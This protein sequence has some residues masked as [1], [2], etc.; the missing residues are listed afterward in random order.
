MVTD[1]WKLF[2]AESSEA[3]FTALFEAHRDLVYTICLRILG[4]PEDAAD[5]FQGAWLRLLAAQREAKGVLLPTSA[6]ETL[7]RYAVLEADRLRKQRSRRHQREAI[8]EEL[9]EFPA[10]GP[11]SR[12]NAAS[13][14]LRTRLEAIIESLP[15]DQRLPI[16]LHYFHGMT[17]RTI[18]A[19][20]ELPL[21]T[22]ATR[23][24]D[25]RRKLEPICRQAGLGDVE[26]VLA[27]VA[28]GALLIPAPGTLQA[29]SVLT[30][31]GA[32]GASAAT[33]L[34]T[35]EAG[36]LVV[37]M[38]KIIAVF[39]AAVIVPLV[40]AVALLGKSESQP[41]IVASVT[42]PLA[43]PAK[44]VVSPS[45]QPEASPTPL[46]PPTESSTPV[47][48]KQT[49]VPTPRV[50]LKGT[51][52]S[53]VTGEPL[54]N[55]PMRITSL[56]YTLEGA[57]AVEHDFVTT[58]TTTVSGTFEI[59]APHHDLLGVWAE[60]PEH[61]WGY[62]LIVDAQ[63][64]RTAE[65]PPAE[66]V[67]TVDFA[68]DA[69]QILSVQTVDAAGDPLPSTRIVYVHP[70]AITSEPG[71][72]G[73]I[74]TATTDDRGL[75]TIDGL[76]MVDAT[77]CATR[78][79]YMPVIAKL[80]AGQ[81]AI[82]LALSNGGASFSG[83]VLDTDDH[84]IA[85]AR[86]RMLGR[87]SAMMTFMPYPVAW[88]GED[89][90]FVIENLLESDYKIIADAAGFAPLIPNVGS[91]ESPVHLGA[92]SN[93]E[94]YIIKL[95]PAGES[96]VHGQVTD[97][98][99]G[100]PMEGVSVRLDRT[101]S[102]L[103]GATRP[104]EA[105]TLSDGT[106][107]IAVSKGIGRGGESL[108]FEKDGFEVSSRQTLS[109]PETGG[110]VL[111]VTML[112]R[113]MISGVIQD[114]DGLPVAD[115]KLDVRSI[116]RTE[117][118]AILAQDSRAPRTN[119]D[120]HFSFRVLPNT[121]TVFIVRKDDRILG[122]SAPI[123]VDEKSPAPIV[124]RLP[125]PGT[126]EV[127]VV[128]TEGKPVAGAEVTLRYRV[129]QGPMTQLPGSAVESSDEAG[130]AKFPQRTAGE[131]RVDAK[132]PGMMQV[133]AASGELPPGAAE[134][135]ATLTMKPSHTLAGQ[136]IDI[137]GRPIG[138]A[139]IDLLSSIQDG[140][141][142]ASTTSDELGDFS[143]RD[144]ATNRIRL[145][146]K[147]GTMTGE[148]SYDLP[149]TEPARLV[150]REPN[151]VIGSVADFATGEPIS[152][153]TVSMDPSPAQLSRPDAG[154]FIAE[155]VE[156]RQHHWLT[157]SAPGY[158]E[159]RAKLFLLDGTEPFT[160]KILLGQGAEL[161]GRIVSQSGGPAAGVGVVLS[162]PN[163]FEAEAGGYLVPIPARE[164][165]RTNPD[166]SF[167]FS[168]LHPGTYYLRAMVL[169]GAGFIEQRPV[170]VGGEKTVD[171]GDLTL[172]NGRTLRGRLVDAKG[173][174]IVGGDVRV[175]T[176]T[177]L[178]GGGMQSMI[179][180]GSTDSDGWFLVESIG[181]GEAVL[182]LRDSKF[183]TTLSDGDLTQDRTYTVEDFSGE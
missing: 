19:A 101:V 141:V 74:R 72:T 92:T 22:V 183:R 41:P 125:K 169:D 88:S 81:S 50:V 44:V 170:E 164:E 172:S 57:A 11:D 4:D 108:S 71:E 112:N 77:V 163:R 118:L 2:F 102:R 10:A 96:V 48:P 65:P 85:N 32:G 123:L 47:A 79:G 89:G 24:R 114:P 106:Y 128:D 16:Q 29:A 64:M 27:T 38:P 132:A 67:Q 97:K 1:H 8:M 122:W 12:D 110:I 174:P 39:A 20:L 55:V 69:E 105:V 80:E 133:E 82:R 14:E 134:V 61:E 45:P 34:V 155:G 146:G 60:A 26:K 5:A 86:V 21:G 159:Y 144:V 91:A 135:T 9:P 158:P 180:A 109:D 137:D 166:G 98:T 115:A 70:N 53:N 40:L 52:R 130:I 162:S 120:G 165:V 73:R 178:P 179:R 149:L 7:A 150:I 30:A 117:S 87:Q 129:Q 154:I 23:I 3:H 182:S 37:P 126:V 58:G 33:S 168:G 56:S 113:I 54:A 121:S 28:L 131:F 100:L 18:A 15:E 49:R 36:R 84:P 62:R 167:R 103:L 51:V 153:F 148:D 171:L 31:W 156:R 13:A 78:P 173:N 90:S 46:P 147:L 145:R 176:K 143:F 139:T 25:G 42:P 75:A 35:S 157:I 6:E 138:G 152:Q 93:I 124:L 111:N 66:Q 104:V 94:G 140:V 136:V 161:K 99:K 116:L 107:R 17:Q 68:L 160:P 119:E 127:L 63:S 59:I 151:T 181:Q 83:R 177:T 142:I 95:D 43:T 76:G 175:S